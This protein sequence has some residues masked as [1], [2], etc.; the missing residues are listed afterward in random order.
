MKKIFI[1]VTTILL[2]IGYC[3]IEPIA[4]ERSNESVHYDVPELSE[5]VM[6]EQVKEII[7]EKYKSEE[8]E[9][10]IVYSD[11]DLV[12]SGKLPRYGATLLGTTYKYKYDLGIAKNQPQN[13]VSFEYGGT[14]YWKDDTSNDVNVGFS[15][16]GVGYSIGVSVGSKVSGVTGYGAWCPANMRCKLSVKKDLKFER[17]YVEVQVSGGGT[18][19]DY[20]NTVIAI[21]YDFYVS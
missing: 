19:R 7:K 12:K 1:G 6:K 18:Y 11:S 3:F 9:N 13:G 10:I 20:V 21:G 2:M 17:W 16:S 8:I 15:I 14:I 4:A 5:E